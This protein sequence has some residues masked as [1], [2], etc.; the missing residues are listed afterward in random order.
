MNIKDIIAKVA[1]GKPPKS[2]EFLLR[3]TFAFSHRGEFESPNQP[4]PPS[5]TVFI[6]QTQAGYLTFDGLGGVIGEIMVN[7]NGGAPQ[8]VTPS[9]SY[10]LAFSPDGIATGTI[11]T[12]SQLDSTTNIG[13]EYHFVVADDWKELKYAVKTA[14]VTNLNGVSQR[15]PKVLVQGTMRKV[16]TFG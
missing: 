3:G 7:R 1:T 10:T 6:P 15:K 13:I 16:Y 14:N 12:T 2:W 8:I 5:P 11:I 4:V 9:G